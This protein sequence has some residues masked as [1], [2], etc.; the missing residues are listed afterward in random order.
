MTKPLS[1][2]SASLLMCLLVSSARGEYPTEIEWQ[3]RPQNWK[4][5]TSKEGI[6]VRLYDGT[7]C[8]Y[9]N[10]AYAIEIDW[11]PKGY[12]AVGQSLYYSIVLNRKPGIILLVKD[13]AAEK[14]YVYRTQ[15]IC[16]KYGITLWV[17][18]VP[19]E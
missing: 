12:E 18:R 4:R 3:N 8:D 5:Y 7:R 13:W 15:T 14:A 16:A 6:E 1:A 2:L 9:V 11:A 17:E 10:A 19:E